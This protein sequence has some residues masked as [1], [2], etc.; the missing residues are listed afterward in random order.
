MS[1]SP[2]FHAKSRE[3]DAGH[4]HD[5]LRALENLAC[6]AQRQ[7]LRSRCTASREWAT[8]AD[9]LDHQHDHDVARAL[10]FVLCARRRDM[11][12]LSDFL[13][14]IA[15]NPCRTLRLVEITH[16]AGGRA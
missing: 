8:E 9:R 3:Y 4:R 10:A 15:E 11:E 5:I 16:P 14:V 13:D 2:F 1:T 6:L 7:V 12:M